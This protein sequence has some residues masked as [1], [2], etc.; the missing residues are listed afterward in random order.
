MVNRKT[1]IVVTQEMRE[2]TVWGGVNWGLP[3]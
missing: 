3:K 1:W 2:D